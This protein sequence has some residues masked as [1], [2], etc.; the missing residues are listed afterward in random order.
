M[1]FVQQAVTVTSIQ[2][3]AQTTEQFFLIKKCHF[4][5]AT[6]NLNKN[7]NLEKSN[8]L[9]RVL[10]GSDKKALLGPGNNY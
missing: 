10:L 4:L 6:R 1:G 8:K 2:N 9:S 5:V 7:F 3:S